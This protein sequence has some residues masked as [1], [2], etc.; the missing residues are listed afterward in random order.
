MYEKG[1]GF[2]VGEGPTDAKLLLLGE[3]PGADEALAGRPF[4]GGAGRL[5]NALLAEAGIRRSSVF[6]DNVLRCRPPG[7]KYPKAKERKEAEA[8]CR[9]YDRKDVHPN[10][11]VALGE[12]A[13]N[14]VTGKKG[15]TRW[16][17]SVIEVRADAASSRANERSCRLGSNSGIPPTRKGR[18]RKPGVE[19][20]TVCDPNT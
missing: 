2:V 9:Q 5:L 11:I 18:K 17:G 4:V 12:K 14:L 3:A 19:A 16:A 7:N 6:V 15:V 10:V 20:T 8:C 1:E 13:L